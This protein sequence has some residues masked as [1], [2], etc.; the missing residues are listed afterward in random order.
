[1]KL[2]LYGSHCGVN[3]VYESIE[4]G[5]PILALPFFGDQPDN[6]AR[7]QDAGAGLMLGSPHDIREEDFLSKI[8]L[9]MSNSSFA[10]NAGR[11]KILQRHAGGAKKAADII[12]M[13]VDSGCS[14]DHLVPFVHTLPWYMY[15]N[16]DIYFIWMMVIMIFY[17]FLRI[18]SDI[19]W[20]CC[21]C[22]NKKPKN[23]TA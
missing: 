16:L 17:T 11:L 3:S 10:K 12:E 9:V 19:C 8:R 2:T 20:I 7:V 13:V 4:A 23:K 18:I 5:V 1:M 22:A 14:V 21:F 6:S 15:Y